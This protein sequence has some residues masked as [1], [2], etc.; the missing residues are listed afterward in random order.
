MKNKLGLIILIIVSIIVG[1]LG[2]LYDIGINFI[3]KIMIILL[4][5]FLELI[6]FTIS[7]ELNHGFVGERNGLKFSV[8]Y[9]GPFTFERE[10]KKFKRIKGLSNQMTYLGRAQIDNGEILNKQDI[11]KTKKAWIKALKAG[12]NSDIIL[13]TA[14]IILALILKLPELLI[15][16]FFI[17]A[18]IFIPSYI[19]GD[20]KHIKALKNDE[21]FTDVIL[22][23]YS[24]AGNELISKE[25]KD[26]LINRI[27]NDIKVNEVHKDNLI[28]MAL[29]A[30]CVYIEGICNNIK[31]LPENIDKIVNLSIKHKS[32]F[33]KKQIEASYYKSLINTAILYEVLIN[34]NKERA[35]AIY[36]YVKDETHNL[37]GEILDFYRVE[38]ILGIAN[39]KSKILDENLMNPLFRGCKGVENIE[40]TINK[41]ILSKSQ[42][43]Y[44]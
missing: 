9:L 38:H 37:P 14:M 7:H 5:F 39:R 34:D 31:D 29:C 36:K 10:N 28:S 26:F 3:S 20:G 4:I 12:P 2:G 22:Y 43:I 27:I 23:T 33:T 11:E 21:V 40:K 42:A 25:S 41:L 18:A 1:L 35:I 19:M 44:N 17:D 13:S 15:A 24:I 30:Q 6:I 32:L 16:T 8:L